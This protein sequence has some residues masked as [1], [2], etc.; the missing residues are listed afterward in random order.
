ML[1]EVLADKET[2]IHYCTIAN[3]GSSQRRLCH[4]MPDIGILHLTL[5]QEHIECQDR[6]DFMGCNL[7][8]RFLGYIRLFQFSV[9][10]LELFGHPIVKADIRGVLQSKVGEVRSDPSPEGDSP[11]RSILDDS[12]AFCYPNVRS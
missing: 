2:F 6:E 5:G 7:K 4:W 12:D 10:D 9:L 11:D 8:L 1:K 3:Q